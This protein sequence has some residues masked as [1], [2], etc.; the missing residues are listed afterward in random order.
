[1]MPWQVNVLYKVLMNNHVLGESEI[2]M[3]KTTK[4]RGNDRLCSLM[5]SS[6]FMSRSFVVMVFL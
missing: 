3:E 1:M 5:V 2:E 6:W 4:I